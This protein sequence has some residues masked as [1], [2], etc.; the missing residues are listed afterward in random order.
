MSHEFGKILLLLFG[1]WFG[2]ILGKTKWGDKPAIWIT[3]AECYA[4]SELTIPYLRNRTYQSQLG[5]L[6][7]Y[8]DA[9]TRAI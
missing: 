1:C 2:H 9:I 4:V 5:E 6:K 3:S 8:Q 7:M